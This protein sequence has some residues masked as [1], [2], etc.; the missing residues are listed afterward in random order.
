MQYLSALERSFD[1]NEVI[2]FIHMLLTCVSMPQYVNTYKFLVNT[3]KHKLQEVYD[4]DDLT[5]R[6]EKAND[7]FTNFTN[8]LEIWDKLEQ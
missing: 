6:L 3:N 7:M 4:E 5:L 1:P 8:K 2:S